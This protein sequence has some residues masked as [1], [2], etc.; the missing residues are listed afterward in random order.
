MIRKIVLK[1]YTT[2]NYINIKLSLY[3]GY[4]NKTSERQ[5]S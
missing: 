5:R 1:Y 2:D 3:L 4:K